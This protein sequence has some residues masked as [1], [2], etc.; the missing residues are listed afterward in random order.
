MQ[1]QYNYNQYERSYNL[2]THMERIKNLIYDYDM[3]TEIENK[4]T[5]T[6]IKKL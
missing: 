3:N 6:Y 2:K 1:N 4:D 5:Q